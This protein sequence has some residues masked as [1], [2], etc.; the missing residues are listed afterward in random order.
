MIKTVNTEINGEIY[1]TMLELSDWRY[2]AAALGII[3]FLDNCNES[4]EVSK[5][6]GESCSVID[7][8]GEIIEDLT[9]IKIDDALFY[10]KKS[11]V[12]EYVREKYLN[13]VEVYFKDFMHH[14]KIINR[15]QSDSYKNLNVDV[16][17]KDKKEEVKNKVKTINDLMTAN[18][19]LKKSFDKK[20][21]DGSNIDEILNIIEKNR[22]LIIEE[23]YRN[24][25]SCYRKYSNE[26]LFG[27]DPIKLCR[28]NGYY[29]DT[30]RKT[31]SISYNWDFN[32]NVAYDEYEFDYIPFAFT[33]YRDSYFINNNF[34]IQ[35][36][37]DANNLIKELEN[38]EET[39][40]NRFKIY[41]LFLSKSNDYKYIDY[42]VEIIKKSIDD[43]F[44][45][46]ILI[47]DESLRV[48]DK[49]NEST[50]YEYIVKSL[51]SGC[52]VGKDS[53]IDIDEMTIANIINMTHLDYII[54]LLLKDETNPRNSNNHGFLLS[55]LI[56]I[57]ELIYKKGGNQVEDKQKALDGARF[58]GFAL[59]N[60]LEKNK[61]ISYRN[62]LISCLTFKDYD[63]F[64]T[65]LLQ[66]SS[67]ANNAKII[68][69]ESEKNAEDNKKMNETINMNFAYKLFEDFEDNKNIA[70]TFVNAFNVNDYKKENK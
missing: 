8:N 16:D 61:V 59:A 31:K 24:G 43:D 12:Y 54:D 48:F 20:K 33:T 10:N 22:Y 27:K 70:Y 55:Q 51:N 49:I 30:G 13:F 56:K 15:L 11:I 57:N 21:F 65:I 6:A 64:C 25:L 60:R 3:R 5:K 26:N 42:E 18:S 2:S 7:E 50:S 40:T 36:L 37:I 63:R 52:K 23:T 4:Y 14:S 35:S 38:Y 47:R 68:N 46:S 17:D 9:H 41:N 66:L 67:Y 29:V 32:T 53:Y 34:T 28:L 45:E 1:D 69:K 44:Y 39:N 58:V 62:K 19:I